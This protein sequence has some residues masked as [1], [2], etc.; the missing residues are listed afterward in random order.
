[1][2]VYVFKTKGSKNKYTT[3]FSL[4]EINNYYCFDV[5]LNGESH[6]I[7]TED[8]NYKSFKAFYL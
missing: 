3:V 2:I 7:L 1:M 4:T 8:M 6:V 5:D